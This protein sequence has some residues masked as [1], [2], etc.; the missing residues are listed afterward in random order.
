MVKSDKYIVKEI[1]LMDKCMDKFYFIF[2]KEKCLEEL[3]CINNQL[4][5]YL[6]TK[7]D[8]FI[9]E[10][11]QIT[12]RRDLEDIKIIKG[13]FMRGIGLKVYLLVREF[14][15]SEMEILMKVSLLMDKNLGKE[16]ID[17]LTEKCTKAVFI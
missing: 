11:Y 2:L 1:S 8:A 7:R 4:K 12:M 16:F 13:I 5:E 15:H 10:P 17:L 3:L 9:A 14:K 6:S